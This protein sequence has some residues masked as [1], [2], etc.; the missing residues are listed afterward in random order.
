MLQL[1]NTSS[2]VDDCAMWRSWGGGLEGFLADHGLDGV[3]AYLGDDWDEAQ[4]SARHIC[5][6][7]LRF[8]RHGLISGV[9]TK[10]KCCGSLAAG[11]MPGC[12]TVQILQQGGW[13]FGGAI[14]RRP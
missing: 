4:L 11:K 8:W 14:W 1:I 9:A 3:E 13:R 6:V 2:Y 7:H 10:R 5:G 12:I